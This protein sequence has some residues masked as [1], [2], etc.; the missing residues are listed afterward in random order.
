MGCLPGVVNRQSSLDDFSKAGVRLFER[1]Q[2][3]MCQGV[4]LLLLVV[5]L[6]S[7][8]AMRG[9]SAGL[10]AWLVEVRIIH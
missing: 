10:I 7:L 1:W 6:V 3:G 2:N 4:H 8:L 5:V 9:G